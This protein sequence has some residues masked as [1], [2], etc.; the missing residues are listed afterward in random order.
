MCEYEFH[1]SDAKVLIDKYINKS[2]QI[3]FLIG[4]N[5]GVLRLRRCI[6][7]RPQLGLGGT[8]DFNRK[9][10]LR[11]AYCIHTSVVGMENKRKRPCM[12]NRM[13][14][15]GVAVAAAAAAFDHV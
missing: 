2:R 1:Q 6:R 12:A 7:Y 5:R 13:T 4:F 14:I 9:P 15:I 3:E 8:A 11:L 10:H